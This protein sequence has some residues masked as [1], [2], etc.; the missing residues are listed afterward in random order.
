MAR[1]PHGHPLP[2]TS[3]LQ[4]SG[5]RRARG[6]PGTEQ[7]QSSGPALPFICLVWPAASSGSPSSRQTGV[8]SP[9]VLLGSCYLISPSSQAGLRGTSQPAELPEPKPRVSVVQSGGTQAATAPRAPAHLEP[10][11]L[12]RKPPAQRWRGRARG[13]GRREAGGKCHLSPAPPIRTLSSA[14]PRG[15][16]KASAGQH[17]HPRGPGMLPG[18]AWPCKKPQACSPKPSCPLPAAAGPVGV[19]SSSTQPPARQAGAGAP[20]SI[21]PEP[22]AA[23]PA[24]RSAS[25]TSCLQPSAG[26]WGGGGRERECKSSVVILPS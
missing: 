23:F 18:G 14:M 1:S 15:P 7:E 2:G 19:H 9:L 13:G 5:R 24:L 20:G 6:S 4:A 10:V 8:R 21:L 12:P 11:A 25:P 16:A 17:G 26:G 22:G 3:P